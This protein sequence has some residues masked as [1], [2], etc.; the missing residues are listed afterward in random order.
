MLNKKQ[1]A[2]LKEQMLKHTSFLMALVMFIVSY[3]PM[4]TTYALTGGPAQPESQ[5]FT[6]IGVSDMVDP[7]TGDFSYNIPLLSVDGYPIN[8]SYSG[9]IGMDQEA[10][11]VG[12]GWS[13][14]PG[15]VNRTVRGL[16]DDFNGEQVVET[17]NLKPQRT[18][19]LSAQLDPE[20]FGFPINKKIMGALTFAPSFSF[21]NYTGIGIGLNAGVEFS[22]TVKGDKTAKLGIEFGADGDLQISPSLS[23]PEKEKK[24]KRKEKVTTKERKIGGNFSTRAGFTGLTMTN[25]YSVSKLN[26]DKKVKSKNGKRNSSIN[27]MQPTYSPGADNQM[28]NFCA[29]FK[30]KLGAAVTGFFAGSTISGSYSENKLLRN[31]EVNKAY[32]LMYSHNGKDNK[33]AL[34]DANTENEGTYTKETPALPMTHE[35]YDVFSVSGQGSSGSYRTHR[36]D[37]AYKRPIFN[38]SLTNSASFGFEVG[39]SPTGASHL[40]VDLTVNSSITTTGAWQLGNEAKNK[41]QYSTGANGSLYEPSYFKHSSEFNIQSDPNHYNQFGA[42]DASRFIID[43]SIPF[44]PQLENSLQQNNGNQ[45]SVSNNKRTVRDN[46]NMVLQI[47]TRN[48]VLQGMGISE[49]AGIQQGYSSSAILNNDQIGEII[50]LG[51]DGSRYVYGLPSYNLHKEEITFSVGASGTT[52]YPT[53]SNIDYSSGIIDVDNIDQDASPANSWGIDNFYNRVQTPAYAHSFLLTAVVSPDYVDADNI[54]GPSKNDLGSYTKFNYDLHNGEYK[55][56]A[57]LGLNTANYSEGLRSDESDDKA[58]IVYGTKEQWYLETIETKNFIAVFHKSEREDALGVE[59]WKGE[60]DASMTTLKL[61][62]IQLFARPDYENSVADATPIK[63]VHFDYTYELCPGVPN[64]INNLGGIS[65][66]PEINGKL[67]LKKVWFTYRNSYKAALNPYEFEYDK[68]PN[69]NI[70]YNYPYNIKA[71]DRWGSY[72]PSVTGSHS[73]SSS[74]LPNN[75]DPYSIQDRSI[76]DE[77][78]SA[79]TLQRIHLPSGGKIEPTYESDDYSHVQNKTA[80]Q[81]MKI[82]GVEDEFGIMQYAPEGT[83]MPISSVI[84]PNRRIAIEIPNGISG[85][86]QSYKEGIKNLYFKVMMR[87]DMNASIPDL[88]EYVT[89]Y[90]EIDESVQLTSSTNNG[91]DVIIMGLKPVKIRKLGSPDYSPMSY[92]GIQFARLNLSR[93]IWS[94]SPFQYQNNL[95]LVPLITELIDAI[96]DIGVGLQNPTQ[97]QYDNNRGREILIG[98][99]WVRLN[100]PDGNKLGG[101]NRVNRIEMSDEWEGMTG[102][103]GSSSSYGQE[104][105]YVME[106]GLTS[107]GVAAYE[108]QIGGDENPFRQPVFINSTDFINRALILD[109]GYFKEEPFGESF[110][111]AASVGYSRVVIENLKNGSITKHASGKV[112]KEF[113]TAKDYPTITRRTDLQNKRWTTSPFGLAS[114]LTQSSVDVTSTS[115]GFY[116]ECNDMHGKPKKEMVFQEGNTSTPITEVEYKYRSEDNPYETDQSMRLKTD[117]RVIREDGSS[118]MAEVGNVYDVTPDFSS[119]SNVSG[120][121]NMQFNLDVTAPFLFGFSIV[122]GASL[123]TTTYK[124]ATLTKVVQKFGILEETVATDLGS[125]VSTKNLAY[126]AKT[127]EVLLTETKTNFEDNVYSMKYPAYWHYDNMGQAADNISYQANLVVNAGNVLLSKSNH[128]FV[129]G[130]EVFVR[131]FLGSSAKAWVTDMTND[132]FKLQLKDGSYVSSGNWSVKVIRSGKRNQQKLP[133][134]SITSREN[135]LNGLYSNAYDAVLQASAIEYDDGWRTYC[136]C[137]E[138]NPDIA[139][140]TNPYVLGIKGNWRPITSFLHLADRDQSDNNNNTNIIEDGVFTSYT[141]FYRNANGKWEIDR[142]DWTYTAEVTEFNP[143]GQELENQDALGRYSAATFGFNQT[144]ATAVG[145]NTRFHELGFDSFEDY[146]FSECADNHF[147]FKNHQNNVISTDAHTG[148][149][150]IRVSA[151]SDVVFNSG[152]WCDNSSCNIS[153]NVNAEGDLIEFTPDGNGASVIIEWDFISGDDELIY[154]PAQNK[155]FYPINSSGTYV[156]TLSDGEDCAKS[157]EITF[158]NGSYSIKE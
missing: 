119:E 10:S 21:N 38:K 41:L 122:P 16:P 102:I 127:G 133:M 67:T 60:I 147:R 158:D 156:I 19:S 7:F 11:W 32:G 106:D 101:G 24:G 81:M 95:G 42:N 109:P 30:Y 124:Q 141:P 145:A 17:T 2:F 129:E 31:T 62:S 87:F 80:M 77:Y 132:G 71:Y 3:I 1:R 89:G 118:S 79:W 65:S 25:D 83:Y 128:P 108:P 73:L 121:L 61:D 107:S 92:A 47:K 88:D 126:D 13:L 51:D 6:P 29:S 18:L 100:R 12:L 110:F 82:V 27:V 143:F 97:Y 148:Y 113:Y 48:E 134:A 34:H 66:D 152:V 111:P 49:M 140:T 155:I 123:N 149:H 69:D 45:F 117:V 33:N 154:N 105:S 153:Y 8:L 74:V 98:R 23:F 28:S 139:S 91:K 22:K 72:K 85:S 14:N 4:Q 136:N 130:D 125:K 9:N 52:P 36:S 84:K 90:C 96:A 56:R 93:Y 151:G 142:K 5:G 68:D 58:S 26:R 63:V 103:T 75:E 157:L 144:L 76:A 78:A 104:Y 116:I 37:I 131:S 57:P 99:S 64:N 146:A 70:S 112:V 43:Q 135:P 120:S 94:N 54:K 15:A 138:N 114:L 40:G 115:Q 59:D 53:T 46:R 150:S 44:F 20:L 86:L 50:N 35:T 55:W 137:F 39:T